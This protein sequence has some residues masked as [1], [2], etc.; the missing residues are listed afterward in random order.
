M[1]EPMNQED[2]MSDQAKTWL[3]DNLRIIVSIFIV[4]AIALGIYSYSQ[5]SEE[6]VADTTTTVSS[7]SDVTN[8][9]VK[10]TTL[11]PS[12]T[13][14][15]TATKPA[16]V[17]QETATAFIETAVKGDGTTHLAR[18]ALMN[19]LEKNPDSSLTGAH[20]VYV[21]DYLRKQL[22]HSGG[23][24]VGTSVE[25]SKDMVRQAIEHSKNLSPKQL[26]NLKKYSDR[27]AAYRM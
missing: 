2:N 23:V 1:E 9:G 3:Q 4:A 22:R 26:Q 11:T 14:K 5:R 21:E 10:D 16:E 8:E 27:V 24:H 17:S 12:S 6:M 7:D 18:R 13:T 20:K 15:P 19:Y 25:F